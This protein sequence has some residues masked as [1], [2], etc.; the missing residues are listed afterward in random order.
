MPMSMTAKV[1]ESRFRWPTVSVAKPR[2]QMVPINSGKA[3]A[4]GGR[5]CRKAQA[6][7]AR[8]PRKATQLARILS[9]EE[10]SISSHSSTGRPVS[11]ISSPP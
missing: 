10:A 4:T 2:A 7:R 1:A 8:T 6:Y 9:W 3:L 11:P 5:H